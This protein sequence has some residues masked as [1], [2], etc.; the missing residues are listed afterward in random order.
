MSTNTARP[1]LTSVIGRELVYSRRYDANRVTGD[2]NGLYI[3]MVLGKKRPEGAFDGFKGVKSELE[4]NLNV[5][6]N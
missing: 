4:S 5:L 2:R 6:W 3:H 1:S